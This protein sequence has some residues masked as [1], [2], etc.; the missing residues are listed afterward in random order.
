[1]FAGILLLDEKTGRILLLKRSE[2]VEASG[3]WSIPGGSP[4][5]FEDDLEAAMREFVE[6]AGPLPLLD[7]VAEADL[8]GAH[9]FL[10]VCSPG[11][12]KPRLNEEHDKAGWFSL[13]ALPEP[14]HPGVCDALDHFWMLR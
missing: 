3:V 5:F 13:W 8:P 6:E 7:V 2:Y 9:T 4:G 14:L 1:M 11:R 12:W 10:A